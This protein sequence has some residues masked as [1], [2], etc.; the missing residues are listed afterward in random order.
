[1]TD[2]LGTVPAGGS[3]A[4]APSAQRCPDR[5]MSRRWWCSV[6][7]LA[8]IV[9]V[10]ALRFLCFGWID[11]LFVM[12]KFHFDIGASTGCRCPRR[13]WSGFCSWCW[14]VPAGW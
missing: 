3:T 14:R 2:A 5:A 8:L 10:S 1:M 13:R 9:M 12:P 6:W 7:P 11:Q 4:G